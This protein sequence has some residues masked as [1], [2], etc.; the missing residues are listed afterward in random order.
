LLVILSEA[1]NLALNL[2][3]PNFALAG[4]PNVYKVLNWLAVVN[5]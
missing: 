3:C 2:P 5:A 4:H 1:K